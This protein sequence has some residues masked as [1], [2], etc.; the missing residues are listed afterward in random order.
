MPDTRRLGM[1]P[2]FAACSS[3]AANASDKY[4]TCKN[5]AHLTPVSM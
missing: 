3:A 4:N 1:A 2:A 5:I